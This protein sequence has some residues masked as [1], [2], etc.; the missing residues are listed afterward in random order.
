[1]M[2]PAMVHQALTIETDSETLARLDALAEALN[3]S[4]DRLAEQALKAF[5]EE[6]MRHIEAIREGLASLDAGEIISHEDL[7]AELRA[8]LEQARASG[9]E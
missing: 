4:R 2:P 9:A 1:M 5:I 7:M 6:Q 8:R 3:S